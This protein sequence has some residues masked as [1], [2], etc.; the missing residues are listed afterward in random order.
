MRTL[1]IAAV[2]AVL[3]LPARAEDP[4]PAAAWLIDHYKAYPIGGRWTV[5]D[6]TWDDWRVMVRIA[7]PADQANRL[8]DFGPAAQNL[9]LGAQG[10]PDKKAPVWERLAPRRDV[11]LVALTEG[12]AFAEVSCSRHGR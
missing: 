3:A 4:P 7:L 8:M 10:C 9:L 6:V 1:L 12:R 2:A 11:Y 5:E